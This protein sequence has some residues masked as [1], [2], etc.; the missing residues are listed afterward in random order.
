MLFA[1]SALGIFLMRTVEDLSG[2]FSPPPPDQIHAEKDFTE[3]VVVSQCAC[4]ELE[5]ELIQ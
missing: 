4:T 1:H 5:I 3:E 2:H